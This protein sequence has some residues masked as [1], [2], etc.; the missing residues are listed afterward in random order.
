M[1]I[2]NLRFAFIRKT[3]E[4]NGSKDFLFWLLEDNFD[5]FNCFSIPDHFLNILS[6]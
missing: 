5:I 3:L 4:N 1:Y 2:V 6:E